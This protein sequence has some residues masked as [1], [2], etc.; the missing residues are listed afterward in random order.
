MLKKPLKE[1]PP[2]L[3]KIRQSFGM[4]VKKKKNTKKFHLSRYKQ[5]IRMLFDLL[6]FIT[7]RIILNVKIYILK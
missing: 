1:N 7:Y 3:Q 4:R 2:K 5:R 6:E